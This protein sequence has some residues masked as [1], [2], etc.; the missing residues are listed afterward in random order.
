MLRYLLEIKNRFLLILITWISTIYVSY[1]NKEV[2]LFTVICSNFNGKATLYYLIF[3]NVTEVFSSHIQLISFL[4]FQVIILPILYHC[5]TFLAPALYYTEY[6]ATNSIIRLIIFIWYS[7]LIFA[8]SVFVPLSWDFFLSFQN[9]M[10]NYFLNLHFEAK[11]S[12]YL[13]F[14]IILCHLSTFYCTIFVIL[15]IFLNYINASTK[16]I[17]KFR[18]MYYY[19]LIF[20]ATALSPPDVFSQITF[21]LITIFLYELVLFGVILR[22]SLLFLSRQQIKTYKHP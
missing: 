18:K 2:L 9:I 4:S 10:K 15:F 21:S 6:R 5:L 14:Y 17:K 1:C 20:F 12:E 22:F 19:C 8:N 11:L 13:N 3:T 7:S 16:V